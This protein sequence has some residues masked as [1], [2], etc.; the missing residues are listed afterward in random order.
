[1]NTVFDSILEVVHYY[2]NEKL[3]FKQAEHMTLLYPGARQAAL[4]SAT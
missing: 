2:S 4:K 1:M 3:P